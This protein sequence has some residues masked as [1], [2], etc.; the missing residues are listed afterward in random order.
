MKFPSVAVFLAVLVFTMV[1]C[2]RDMVS[3]GRDDK[4]LQAISFSASVMYRD[5][6]G[7]TKAPLWPESDDGSLAEG[8]VYGENGFGVFATETGIHRYRDVTASPNFM[9]NQQVLSED[10]AWGYTPVKYWP[11]EDSSRVSFFAYAP[12]SD[13]DSSSPSDN[14][15][16]YCI[17]SCS[18][19]QDVGDPWILYYLHPEPDKQVDL[20]Y[21]VPILDRTYASVPADNRLTFAF[22]HAL[23]V[24]GE[25]IQVDLTDELKSELQSHVPSGFDKVELYLDSLTV[26]YWLT[27]KARLVLWNADGQPNWQPVMSEDLLARREMVLVQ[28]PDT[29]M[30]VYDASGGGVPVENEVS[31]RLDDKAMLYIP[32]ELDGY[33]QTAEFTTSLR[34]VMSN[35]GVTEEVW[36]SV[37]SSRLFL[38]TATSESNPEGKKMNVNLHI[39][40]INH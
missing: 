11:G 24:F 12:Y 10:G 36:T 5:A 2:E 20:L 1:S 37:Q 40:N 17:P 35:G 13:G 26:T 25:V 7:W 19:P 31:Y 29:P 39:G 33:P 15:A 3:L 27:S 6:D 23:A 8:G 32:L 22:K 21:A 28:E 38:K 16:G 4:S 14:P 30:Y 18:L 34:A 9:C